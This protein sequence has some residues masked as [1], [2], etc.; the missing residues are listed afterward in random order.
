MEKTG[1]GTMAIERRE[2][3]RG[4][5]KGGEDGMVGTEG[6]RGRSREKTSGGMRTGAEPYRGID[7]KTRLFG[8]KHGGER[9]EQKSYSVII[10]REVAKSSSLMGNVNVPCSCQL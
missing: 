8:W 4:G 6:A 3:K 7:R 5:K 10:E 1:P 2:R 9:E